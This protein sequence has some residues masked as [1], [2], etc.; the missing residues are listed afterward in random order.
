MFHMISIAYIV[1]V[2]S[3]G[4]GIIL[5]GTIQSRSHIAVTDSSKIK[6]ALLMHQSFVSTAPLGPGNSG[7]LNFLTKYG[8]MGPFIYFD[9]KQ[10]THSY[11]WRG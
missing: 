4:D 10:V 7:A 2:F 1:S 5:E 3:S 8:K 9:L 6:V 11:I